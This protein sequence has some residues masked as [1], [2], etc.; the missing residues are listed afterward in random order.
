MSLFA[1]LTDADNQRLEIAIT[2]TF[3]HDFL[4]MRPGQFLVAAP[5]TALDLSK[6]LAID[7]GTNG[8]AVVLT[9]ANYFGRANPTIWEWIKAKWGNGG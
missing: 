9:I 6:R 7:D 1:V 4:K 3:P 5:G 2:T 8:A